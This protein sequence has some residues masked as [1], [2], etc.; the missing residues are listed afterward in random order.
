MTR[1]LVATGDDTLS[2]GVAM[3]A[4]LAA[5]AMTRLLAV[6]AMTPCWWSGD[7]SLTGGTGND[8]SDWWYWR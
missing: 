3:T 7:D 1:L 6:L 4:W 5:M 2:G 8:S